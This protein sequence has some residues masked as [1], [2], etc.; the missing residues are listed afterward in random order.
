MKN[1][2]F[3]KKE[4]IFKWDVNAK[5][6]VTFGHG[7][8]VSHPEIS[9]ADRANQ[10]LPVCGL[11]QS[12]C[13]ILLSRILGSGYRRDWKSSWVAK[14]SSQERRALAFGLEYQSHECSANLDAVWG[15]F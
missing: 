8:N 12:H 7:V 11:N 3:K 14:C 15:T 9:V 13:V 6:A 4:H 5:L 2:S 10:D 1:V